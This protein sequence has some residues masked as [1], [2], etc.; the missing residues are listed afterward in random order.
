MCAVQGKIRLVVDKEFTLEQVR[1]A[2]KYAESGHV[3]G[4]VVIKI[5]AV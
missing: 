5:G 3:R 4:K 1:D 2:Q